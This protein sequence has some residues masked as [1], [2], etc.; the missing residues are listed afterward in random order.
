MT[1]VVGYVRTDEGE[2]AFAAAIALLH[3]G[4]RLV[5]VHKAE[6]SELEGHSAEQ[7]A[8]ALHDELAGR[9]VD[10]DVVTLFA[11]DEPADVIVT[12]AEQQDARLIVIGLRRRSAVGKLLLGSTAQAVLFNAPCPVLS[13]RAQQD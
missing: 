13:V 8:D 9:G 5:V 2:A 1:V 3:E 11:G 7:D 12:Q 10:P 6:P 4:E